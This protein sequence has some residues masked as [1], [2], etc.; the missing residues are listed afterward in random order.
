MLTELSSEEAIEEKSNS[1]RYQLIT[2]VIFVYYV[3]IHYMVIFVCYVLIHVLCVN[4][5]IRC[6]FVY[7]GYEV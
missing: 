1:F 7:L 2:S 4:E 3:L 5:L 6:D